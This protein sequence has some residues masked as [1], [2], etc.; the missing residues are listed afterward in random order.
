MKKLYCSQCG[1]E[2]PEEQLNG[3]N[4]TATG[5]DD[6]SHAYCKRLVDCHSEQAKAVINEL[7]DALADEDQED[8]A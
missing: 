2:R 3:V 7:L 8:V 1:C 6:D 5:W 4:L